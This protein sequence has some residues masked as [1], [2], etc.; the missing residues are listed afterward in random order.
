MNDELNV[1]VEISIKLNTTAPVLK[2]DKSARINLYIITER[3][4]ER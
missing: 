1:R 4:G 2:C 3:E